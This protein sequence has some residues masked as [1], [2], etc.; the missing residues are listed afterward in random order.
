MSGGNFKWDAAAV[1]Q[2]LKK[3]VRT[4]IAIASKNGNV[5]LEKKKQDKSMVLPQNVSQ[6]NLRTSNQDWWSLNMH[7]V[8]KLMH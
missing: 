5:H 2:A 6:A 7:Q 8:I 1:N 3:I 4:G